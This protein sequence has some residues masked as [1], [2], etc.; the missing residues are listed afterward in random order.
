MLLLFSSDS[1]FTFPALYCAMCIALVSDVVLP[2]NFNSPGSLLATI[3]VLFASIEDESIMQWSFPSADRESF[4]R[5]Q[6]VLSALITTFDETNVGFPIT[7]GTSSA[8]TG[9]RL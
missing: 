1:Q 2:R 7:R 3:A 6:F 4:M 9:F 8:L 5:M